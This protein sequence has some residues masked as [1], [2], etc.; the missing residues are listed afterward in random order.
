MKKLS[1]KAQALKT[2]RFNFLLKELKRAKADPARIVAL[3]ALKYMV[4][5]DQ[6]DNISEDD[7]ERFAAEDVL[8][9][10]GWIEVEMSDLEFDE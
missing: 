5:Y 10:M 1:K 2:K 3:K 4:C 6:Y 9:Q 7:K 8:E